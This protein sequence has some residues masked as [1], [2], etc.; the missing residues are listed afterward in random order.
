MIMRTVGVALLACGFSFGQAT[1]EVASIK[2][3]APLEFG[4]TIVHRSVTKT[5]GVEGRLNYEG[6]SL[7]DL[8][9]DAYR[10]PHRQISGPA[11]LTSQRFDI[12]AVMP[13]PLSND[14]I[15]EMLGALLQERFKLKT[16]REIKEELVY[17]LVPAS[18]GPKLPEAEK[19]TGTGI[20]GRSTKTAEQV[21]AQTTLAR[22]AEY[23][24][25]RLD[26]PVVDQTGLAGIY[27]IHVEWMPD[28]AAATGVDT[29]GP[30]L[31]TAIQ[32]QLGL[33]LV[34]GKM[35]VQLLVVDSVEKYPTDN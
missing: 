12:L 3:A 2:P 9:G 5:K 7:M 4:R 23:L 8:I 20:S 28:N 13:A 17:R 25:E 33:R 19:E 6:I 10:V 34:A 14:Q 32:E 1:F 15:P 22:F 18:S 29:A 16:H 11:W 35:A 30:S 26:R 31:F 27:S 24:S 21:S